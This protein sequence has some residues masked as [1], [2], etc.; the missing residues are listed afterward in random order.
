[1]NIDEKFQELLGRPPTNEEQQRFLKIKRLGRV[2]RSDSFWSLV[3]VM[4][5]YLGLYGEMPRKISDAVKAVVTESRIA[6]KSGVDAAARESQ[7]TLVKEVA[8]S[9]QAL[10]ENV[11]KAERSW[12]GSMMW[13]A[14]S[15]AVF[16]FIIGWLI[17]YF[18]GQYVAWDE[19]KAQEPRLVWLDSEEGKSVERARRDGTLAW[20]LSEKADRARVLSGEGAIEW[21]VSDAGTDARRLS[22]DGTID[23]VLNNV[24]GRELLARLKKRP[25]VT[26]D[27][28]KMLDCDWDSWIPARDDNPA[29]KRDTEVVKPKDEYT[30]GAGGLQRCRGIGLT[31]WLYVPA[32]RAEL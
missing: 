31:Y 26:R 9:A 5:S 25:D 4:E 21:L 29:Q 22:A 1:M 27:L 24:S 17:A 3:V 8:K 15:V 2:S 6:A 13:G 14:T 19:A 23:F 32:V 20:R 10:A 16:V 28:L 12:W 7:A 18:A 30:T 11:E